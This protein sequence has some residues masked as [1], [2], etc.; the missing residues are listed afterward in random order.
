MYSYGTFPTLNPLLYGKT[1]TP[2]KLNVNHHRVTSRRMSVHQQVGEEAI[3][4]KAMMPVIKSG[5]YLLSATKRGAK[6]LENAFNTLSSTITDTSASLGMG[7]QHGLRHSLPSYTPKTVEMNSSL[8]ITELSKNRHAS[9]SGNLNF[10]SSTEEVVLNSRRKQAILVGIFIQLQIRQR[11]RVGK[12]EA[13]ESSASMILYNSNH[14]VI[15]IRPAIQES[16]A[17]VRLQGVVRGYFVR[18]AIKRMSSR[19]RRVQ[20]LARGRRIRYVYELVIKSVTQLLAVC[21]GY[22]TRQRLS[23]LVEGRLEVYRY[24]IALLWKRSFT[25]LCYRTNFWFLVQFPGLVQ[26][27]LAHTEIIRLWTL[28]NIQPPVYDGNMGECTNDPLF[29]VANQLGISNEIHWQVLKVSSHRPTAPLCRLFAI[30]RFIHL[31][32]FHNS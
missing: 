26:L 3:L 21:R 10:V 25:P 28:L 30:C 19:V 24:H 2:R 1:R 32:L 13:S 7:S 4:K 18:A 17:V 5:S 9:M 23:T 22:V 15:P 11:L 31:S 6:N 14:N 16:V 12:I 8:P 20:A 27:E 29:I